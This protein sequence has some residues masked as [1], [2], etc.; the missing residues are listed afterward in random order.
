MAPKQLIPAVAYLRKSTK[1]KRPDGTERQEKSL[2]QQR[3]E[4]EK[5]ANGRYRI[6]RW[7]E[8]E[9]VSGWKRDGK[10]PQFEQMLADAKERRDFQAIVCDDLDRFSRADVGEVF[11]DTTALS[12]AGVKTIHC[13]NQ[14]LYELGEST[15]IGRIIKMVVDIHGGNEFSRKLSRRVALAHRNRAKLGKRAGVPPYGFASDGNG[16]LKHGDRTHIKV[17]RNIFEWFTERKWSLNGIVTQLRNDGVLAPRGGE[18]S[19]MA[20]K[21]VLKRRAYRG[22]FAF[23]CTQQGRFYTIREDNEVIEAKDRTA[24]GWVHREPTIRIEGAYKPLVAPELWDAAQRRLAGFSMKG[25]RRPRKEGYALSRILICGHCGKPM[26]GCRPRRKARRVYR[27][28]TQAR[29][30][31]GAC[32]AYW[33]REEDILPFVLRALGEEISDLTKMLTGPPDELRWPRQEQREQRD[34]TAR[35]REKLAAAIDLAENNLLACGDPRTRQSLDGKISAMRAELDQLD[36]QLA[37]VV[38]CGSGYSRE[39]LKA[40]NAWWKEFDKRAVSMPVPHTKIPKQMSLE[41]FYQDPN[42]DES[43]LLIDARVVNEALHELG[44]EVRLR[45]TTER[46][47]R[48]RGKK[49]RE[50]NRY[51]LAAGRLRLGQKRA[52]FRKAVAASACNC[53]AAAGRRDTRRGTGSSRPPALNSQGT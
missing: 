7:Y 4:I 11:T 45:W 43:A 53:T 35:E 22:D 37:E 38:G 47:W 52:T 27:C 20:I 5:L 51:T 32:G 49:R 26:H 6:I 33:V 2:H 48:G 31:M 17:V 15:D 14:G 42:A 9:G 12:A 1:G 39:D 10:R 28:S 25:C 16:G 30:G 46:V 36:T 34:Q 21:E 40:L 41:H 13:V 24:P 3:G 50:Q 8:D 19:V 18:W 44:A 23:G 29:R